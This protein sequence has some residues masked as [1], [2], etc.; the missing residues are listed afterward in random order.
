MRL[1][2]GPITR[3][4][5]S[6]VSLTSVCIMSVYWR[7]LIV[8]WTSEWERISKTLAAA[9]KGVSVANP[10]QPSPPREVAPHEVEADI[11]AMILQEIAETP[12]P[13]PPPPARQTVKLK[14]NGHA[15]GTGPPKTPQQSKPP[16]TLKPKPPVVP[17]PLDSDDDDGAKDLLEEVLAIEEEQKQEKRNKDPRLV[18]SIT[19]KDRTSE[20]PLIQEV[21]PVA[22][23][24]RSVPTPPT[25]KVKKSTNGHGPP[26]S[27]GKE[28]EI[29][30]QAPT[31]TPSKHRSGSFVDGFPI[32]EKKCRE[33]L[34][35]LVVMPQALLFRQPVDAELLG[36]PTSV[37]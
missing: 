7:F 8:W 30:R 18:M 13:L 3:Q 9:D 31:P 36:C 16:K 22:G 11:D 24:S 27:K 35:K 32:N 20:D 6:K 10:T 17:P 23:P 33:I 14:V 21:S 2:P 26:S 28:K 5:L 25:L 4:Q 1:A 12:P 37:W 29:I 34:K 19:K 15:N